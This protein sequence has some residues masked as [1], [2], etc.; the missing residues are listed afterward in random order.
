MSGS[1]CREINWVKL[2]V[3]DL[4][5]GGR[6]LLCKFLHHDHRQSAP[7]SSLTP[8]A[9]R[10]AQLSSV[11]SFYLK[12]PRAFFP[13]HLGFVDISIDR[14]MDQCQ[15]VTSALAVYVVT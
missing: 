3:N 7:I 1:H 2:G 8:R 14:L 9:H 10:N 15:N 4:E 13:E 6:R 5:I 12:R 11:L